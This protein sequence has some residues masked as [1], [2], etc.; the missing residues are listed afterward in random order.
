MSVLSRSGIRL[1][2]DYV[3]DDSRLWHWR[4]ASN[5]PTDALSDGRDL[6]RFSAQHCMEMQIQRLDNGISHK[7]YIICRCRTSTGKVSLV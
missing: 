3:H 5:V 4:H 7:P 2:N 6:T 1:P